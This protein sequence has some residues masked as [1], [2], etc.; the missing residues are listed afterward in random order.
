MQECWM[1]SPD[2]RPSF[3]D[4]KNRFLAD[5][6]IFDGLSQNQSHIMQAASQISDN[7][8]QSFRGHST[9]VPQ[10]PNSP[11]FL[12]SPNFQNFNNNS[13]NNQNS[14]NQPLLQQHQQS[15]PSS[16]QQMNTCASFN[17]PAPSSHYTN[18]TH[19]PKLL[20]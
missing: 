13:N 14:I 15:S 11:K 16:N 9:S 6:N 18:I 12:N 5:K 10:T 3:A 2:S 20:Q 19:T 4:L 7:R 17:E 1:T 8:P